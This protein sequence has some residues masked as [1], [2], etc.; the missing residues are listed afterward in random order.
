MEEVPSHFSSRGHRL[1][2]KQLPYTYP[3][4]R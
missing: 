4:I 1:N 3:G 2:Q